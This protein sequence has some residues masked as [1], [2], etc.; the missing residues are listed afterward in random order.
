M[1]AKPAYGLG[2]QCVQSSHLVAY[3]GNY[4]QLCILVYNIW[5][6]IYPTLGREFKALLNK[7]KL[8]VP[9]LEDQ[10]Q[11]AYL[12]ETQYQIYQL[13]FYLYPFRFIKRFFKSPL[14]E[15]RLPPS[16]NSNLKDIIILLVP[17][18]YSLLRLVFLSTFYSSTILD[19]IYIELYQGFLPRTNKLLA[20]INQL[21]QRSLYFLS[22]SLQAKQVY[23]DRSKNKGFYIGLANSTC[24][25]QIPFAQNL[26]YIVDYI[27]SS[28]SIK[29]PTIRL[30]W[31]ISI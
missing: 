8:E 2:L 17:F 14:V 5:L 9:L 30:D 10:L 24:E 15:N 25:I 18:V 27:Y 31:L 11:V 28:C 1:C 21:D 3:E 12:Y 13:T 29:T 20:F 23:I 6:V 22:F 19:L 7:Y 16:P 4:L 26:H